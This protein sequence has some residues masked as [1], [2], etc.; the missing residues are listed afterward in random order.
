MKA[1]LAVAALRNAT[2][3]RDPVGTVVRSDRGSQLQSN[4]LVRMITNNGL[5][6]SM[7][8]V[9]ACDDNAAT[10]SFFALQHEYVLDQQR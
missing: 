6:G 5:V 9:G 7:G 4:A 2:I 10:E 1:S 8:R 3:R